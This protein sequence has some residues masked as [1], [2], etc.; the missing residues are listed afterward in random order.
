QVA[1][2]AKHSP[3][4]ERQEL[5]KPIL[6]GGLEGG[7]VT[8]RLERASADYA[9]RRRPRVTTPANARIARPPGP[10]TATTKMLV[11]EAE[12]PAVR[13]NSR[14]MPIVFATAGPGW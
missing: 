9:R 10:G 11:K 4:A 7:L 2:L 5:N 14:R 13:V 3:N 6:A 12:S 1:W 8:E